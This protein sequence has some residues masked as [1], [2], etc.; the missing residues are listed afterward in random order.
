[1]DDQNFRIQRNGSCLR[2][3]PGH[4]SLHLPNR[5]YKCP[6]VWRFSGEEKRERRT[7]FDRGSV[8]WTSSTFFSSCRRCGEECRGKTDRRWREP[9]ANMKIKTFQLIWRET[10]RSSW[11]RCCI[12]LAQAQ[13]FARW[14]TFDRTETSIPLS[15]A[16]HLCIETIE[17]GNFVENRRGG[18]WTRKRIWKRFLFALD[19]FSNLA[20]LQLPIHR[21]L[22][23]SILSNKSFYLFLRSS[24]VS[25]SLLNKSMQ[26]KILAFSLNFRSSREDHAVRTFCSSWTCGLRR[27]RSWKRQTLLYHQYHRSKSCSCRWSILTRSTS[28]T[29][30]QSSSFNKIFVKTFT[31]RSFENCQ[32]PVGQTS[33]QWEMATIPLVQEITNETFTNENDRF[34]SI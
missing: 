17:R 19:I 25:F 28:S 29:E 4:S 2:Q 22:S 11:Q 16:A 15:F 26:S 13:F 1:M 18:R 23:P 14:V 3:C 5:N 8:R 6:S 20:D 24:C 27:L 9:W 32:G 34:R 33:S 21:F 30:H 10:V 7:S 31:G 12:A